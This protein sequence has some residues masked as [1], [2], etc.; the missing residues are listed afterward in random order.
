MTVYVLQW[1]KYGEA[2]IEGIFTSLAGAMA[3]AAV[4]EAEWRHDPQLKCWDYVKYR[5]GT[6]YPAVCWQ[7]EECEVRS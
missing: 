5:P 2:R 6:D 4:P 3:H 1:I 7:I